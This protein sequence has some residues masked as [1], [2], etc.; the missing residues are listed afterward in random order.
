MTE[1]SQAVESPD[2]GERAEERQPGVTGGESQLRL[3]GRLARL[4]AQV[5]AHSE[6]LAEWEQSVRA[7][8]QHGLVLRLVLLGLALAGFFYLKMRGA[9]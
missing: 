9:A 5:R 7:K 6:R 4:E 8:K 1:E 2:G 3:E